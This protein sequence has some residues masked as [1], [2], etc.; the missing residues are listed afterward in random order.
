[1]MSDA[2]A[3]FRVG[4]TEAIPSPAVLVYPERIASNVRQMIATAGGPHRL[5]PH[6]KTHKLP[7]VVQLQRALGIDKFK[8]A[9]IAEAE[10]VARCGAAHVLLATQ[11]VGPAI[12]RLLALIETF[13]Q[14]RFAAIVDDGSV[15]RAIS[16]AARSRRLVVD[17]LVDIDC[18][19]HRT[20]I[21]PGQA[22]IELYALIAS[23][24]GVKPAGL[25]AY[26]GHVHDREHD[27]REANVASVMEP[28]RALQAALASRSLI[29]P[30]LVAG[31]TP[32]FPIHARTPDVEC[33]A[34][35]CVLW[36]GWSEASLP[37]LRF[38]HAA[39]VLTRVISKPAPHLLC[40][41]LGH[42]AIASEMQPPRVAFPELPDAVALM[43]NEEHLVIETAHAP[44]IP[45]GTALYGI[46][47]HI[48]PT[49]ALH[50]SVTVIMNGHATQQWKVLARDRALTI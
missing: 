37:D 46:P 25:H 4:N 21:A 31:G 47:W 49:M 50:A 43:H 26:D 44:D 41:D 5:C 7:E 23:T 9:T 27:K 40:L 30:R 24:P 10:M 34:G 3:W 33:S 42:K 13:P 8:C 6:V 17:L 19:M 1:M 32:T 22:A 2:T 29:V 28:V 39:V 35:T 38:Q 14:T 20:G 15:V 18:G 45:L 12:P 11:P 48:C 36:D 16:T